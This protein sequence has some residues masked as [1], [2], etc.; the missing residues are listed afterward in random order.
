VKEVSKQLLAQLREN[1][2]RTGRAWAMR[3]VAMSLWDYQFCTWAQKGWSSWLGWV[4]RCRSEPV[5]K[6]GQT[7]NRHPRG[8]L[9]A[10]ALKSHNGSPES[11]K[12]RIQ[13]I[14][15]KACQFAD[16]ELFRNAIDFHCGGLD[17][18]KDY[19]G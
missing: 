13:R 2:V 11:M 4:Q 7:I 8:T 10:V 1:V 9:N 16:R 19:E 12:S 17:L 15:R 6:V 5:K 14:K 3:Q 18:D